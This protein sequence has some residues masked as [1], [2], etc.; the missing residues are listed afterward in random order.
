MLKMVLKVVAIESIEPMAFV[1][2]LFN[3]SKQISCRKSL[4][5]EP[6]DAI[7]RRKIAN[8]ESVTFDSYQN[9]DDLL[10]PHTKHY[11]PYPPTWLVTMQRTEKNTAL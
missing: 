8:G 6:P 10:R 5:S 1:S 9:T 3:D 11:E 7:A 4:P 2:L